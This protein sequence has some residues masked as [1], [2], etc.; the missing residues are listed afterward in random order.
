MMI[1]ERKL[2]KWLKREI[3]LLRNGVKEAARKEDFETALYLKA[4]AD[5]QETT[6]E[7]VCEISE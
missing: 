2:V 1:D 4:A 6:L 7:Y 3:R 5:A